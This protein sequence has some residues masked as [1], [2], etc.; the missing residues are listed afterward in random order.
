MGGMPLDL[1]ESRALPILRY[2]A[3]NETDMNFINVGEIAQATDI[4]GHAVVIELERLIDAGYIP[5]TLQKMMTGG[6]P[7]SWFLSKSRLTERGARA[8]S[9]WP[10]AENF[11][12][13]LEFRAAQEADPARKQALMTM[14]E[15]AKQI[16]IPALSEILAAAARRTMGLP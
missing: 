11:V 13:T 9:V 5:G 14:L 2:I 6:D 16:G 10:R 15:V 3:A 12:Q 4:E 1:W 8:V 7:S